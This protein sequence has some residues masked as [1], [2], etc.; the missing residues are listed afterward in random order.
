MQI[1]NQSIPVALRTLGYNAPSIDAIVAH[2]L[3]H[4]HVVDA[5][6]LRTE[7]YPVFD[8][9]TGER[10]IA[11][12]GHLLMM[13]A[14]Q[15]FLGAHLEDRE[16]ARVGHGGG[17]RAGVHARVGSSGLRRWRSTGTTASGSAALRGLL[18]EH[19]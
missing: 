17:H 7:H 2:I 15:P 10:P 1:V 11:V 3:A 6:G 9:A 12:D 14:V 18:G 16:H 8:T 5:P 4:G 19:G 13:A